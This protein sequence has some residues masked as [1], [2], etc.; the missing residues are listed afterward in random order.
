MPSLPSST[1]FPS[2]SLSAL[3][4]FCSQ[5]AVTVTHVYRLILEYNEQQ[6]DFPMTPDQIERYASR[7]L[8]FA[9]IWALVG[10]ARGSVRQL[11]S[12]IIR[13]ACTIPLPPES[14]GDVIDFYVQLPDGD[15]KP[16]KEKVP[17]IRLESSKMAGTDV[18][19][20]TLDTTR[21]EDVLFSW[22]SE[23]QPIVLCG[24]PG[25]GSAFRCTRI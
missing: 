15:W 7:R 22:L 20:P 12:S 16:W 14:E 2:L 17:I 21:H 6:P 9:V 11:V 5:I 1:E 23:K 8:I 24:P 4:P 10:D 18:V 19:V 25:S 3:T 13:S